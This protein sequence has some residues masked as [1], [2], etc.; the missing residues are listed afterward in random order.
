MYS[1]SVMTRLAL[2]RPAVQKLNPQVES[3]SRGRGEG[4]IV[5][6][7]EESHEHLWNNRNFSKQGK[8]PRVYKLVVVP[9]P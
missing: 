6:V 9:S 3:G 7:Q 8:K 5:L 1:Q 4:E 2:I